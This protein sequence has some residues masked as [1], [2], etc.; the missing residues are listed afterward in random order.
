[1][2]R[3]RSCT[4]SAV[5]SKLKSAFAR[6]GIAETVISDNGPCYSSEE[7]RRFADAWD[8]TH[9]TTSPR[10]PR[11]NGLAERTVQTAK[12]ILDKT[13]AENKDLYLA[14]LEYRNTPVDNLQSPAQ[15]LMSRRLRSIL[16]MTGKQLQPHVAP[17]TAVH[18]RREACQHR[19]QTYYNRTTRP[20]SHLPVGTPIRFWQE[21]GSWRPATVTQHADTHR[22][23]YIQTR[24]GQTLRRNR[25]HLRESRETSHTN[26]TQNTNTHASHALP[27]HADTSQHTNTHV[28]RIHVEGD[29][30]PNR[31]H[32]S[33]G[34]VKC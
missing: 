19:Q 30:R 26:S 9:I 20:L 22:S 1:M 33:D 23:Y 8:F 14:L 28:R 21:D 3:L 27:L 6:H 4:S 17:Q 13:M 31:K 34:V 11:S 2:E 5:I 25:W 32:H 18:E 12:R 29:R 10:Y 16:P 7:F 15:L 24:D